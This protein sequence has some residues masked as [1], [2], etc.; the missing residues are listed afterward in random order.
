MSAKHGPAGSPA[1]RARRARTVWH[2]D[3][4]VTHLAGDAGSSGP[5]GLVILGAVLG[6]L[7]A[8]AA[9]RAISGKK[10]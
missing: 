2:S 9:F 7:L 8:W 1:S 5:S 10:K 3:T 4:V 6:V